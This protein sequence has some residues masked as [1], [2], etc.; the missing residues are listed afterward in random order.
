MSKR[1]VSLDVSTW[2]LW[3]SKFSP[4]DTD[5]FITRDLWTWR[6]RE[7][8]RLIPYP[9]ESE[10]WTGSTE[11]TVGP[12]AGPTAGQ[13]GAEPQYQVPTHKE[14]PSSL[15]YCATSM[16]PLRRK[17]SVSKGKFLEIQKI[18]LDTSEQIFWITHWECLAPNWKTIRCWLIDLWPFEITLVVPLFLGSSVTA[19]QH[20]PT[21][22]AA[23]G[24]MHKCTQRDLVTNERI[25]FRH[26]FNERFCKSFDFRSHF[27]STDIK[28][29]AQGRG[30]ICRV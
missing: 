4:L 5:D 11:P 8:T 17:L 29:R 24:H 25:H 2:I 15:Q 22:S 10:I 1:G 13:L 3:I 21:R 16:Y 7:E 14:S 27:L 18:L 20:P 23:A 6:W 28:W 12:W 9:L 30:K 19:T 26:L